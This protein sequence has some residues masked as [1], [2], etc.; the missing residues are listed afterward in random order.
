MSSEALSFAIRRRLRLVEFGP[1]M[2]TT[3]RI[4]QSIVLIYFT[5]W[6]NLWRSEYVINEAES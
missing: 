3:Y 6:S 1:K 2:E 4:T 5:V